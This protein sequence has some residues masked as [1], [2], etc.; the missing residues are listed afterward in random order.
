MKRS[1]KLPVILLLFIPLIIAAIV[2]IKFNSDNITD[3]EVLSIRI[4]DSSKVTEIS[5]K[6]GI[7]FYVSVLDNS[8]SIESAAK[9]LSEY[10]Q[11]DVV[12]VK[13]AKEISYKYYLSG[14]PDDCIYSDA[15]GN[16][17]R[18]DTAAA[19]EL[20][21]RGEMSS[22][23]S[24]SVAPVMTLSSGEESVYHPAAEYINWNYRNVEGE[25]INV[26]DTGKDEKQYAV[27]KSK[28][29]NMS[30]DIAP[31][32]CFITISN[33]ANT[34]FDGDISTLSNFS[35]GSDCELTMEVRASWLKDDF[36]DSAEHYGEMNYSIKLFYDVD[37]SC[38]VSESTSDPGELL[39]VRVDN[40]V[41]ES[42]EVSA[43]FP[44]A[45]KLTM[46]DCNGGKIALVPISLEAQPGSYTITVKNDSRSF[47]LP[48]TVT[49]K[50]FSSLKLDASGFSPDAETAVK[51]MTAAEST[52]AKFDSETSDVCAIT[53]ALISPIGSAD[54]WVS[55]RFGSFITVGDTK[56]TLRQNGISYAVNQDT[57]IYAP[58]D[59]TVLFADSSTVYGGVVIIDHG[60]GL[61]SSYYHLT[62]LR[63]KEG[64]K[65]SLN[66]VLG[67][68]APGGISNGYTSVDINFS[69]GGV[70]VNPASVI[71]SAHD[72]LNITSITDDN[73][74]GV[75]AGAVVAGIADTNA[76]E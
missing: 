38:T 36:D 71:I 43:D 75:D 62:D 68:V 47:E 24:N 16:L 27:S 10:T 37:A 74:L 72:F 29:L 2:I 21:K 6:D 46:Y 30:F 20:L 35:A 41:N 26:S 18:I 50:Q 4:T 57:P 67:T 3:T 11:I 33:G 22:A 65:V 59:G 12:Y 49:Q 19:T 55:G 13:L 70:Y 51:E 76:A 32:T 45:E 28:L 5:D 25:F 52:F 61:H 60:M 8:T 64:D 53:S 54:N 31:D 7:A 42:F 44:T 58:C 15:D 63:I 66:Q 73:L 56:T 34:L 48:I 69:V 14:S 9:D 17:A 39:F 23:Y 1:K 40:A